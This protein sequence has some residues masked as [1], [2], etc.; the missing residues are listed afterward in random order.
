MELKSCINDPFYFFYTISYNIMSVQ[1]N[2][3]YQSSRDD[4]NF[5]I[6]LWGQPDVVSGQSGGSAIWRTDTLHKTKLFGVPNCLDEYEIRDEAID[7]K[8]PVP[9]KENQYASI[10]IDIDPEVLQFVLNMSG[11]LMYDS[12]QGLLTARGA[13]LADT[14]STLFL[15]LRVV[16]N[17]ARLRSIQQKGAYNRLVRAM[18]KLDGP[19]GINVRV[20]TS[21]FKALCRLKRDLPTAPRKGF[22]RG[23]FDQNG[24]MPTK[25]GK[26]AG[27]RRNSA[28]ADVIVQKRAETVS[29]RDRRTSHVDSKEKIE[30]LLQERVWSDGDSLRAYNSG[31]TASVSAN[32]QTSIAKAKLDAARDAA[33]QRYEDQEKSAPANSNKASKDITLDLEGQYSGATDRNVEITSVEPFVGNPTNKGRL[34]SQ[35]RSA[36]D[37]G[38]NLAQ[39]YDQ[40]F[41]RDVQITNIEPFV[42]NPTNKGRAPSQLRDASD[43]GLNLAQLYDQ[44]FDRDVEITSVEPFRGRQAGPNFQAPSFSVP[45][46]QAGKN[47]TDNW[48]QQLA[49]EEDATVAGTYNRSNAKEHFCGRR[50]Y[51][52]DIPPCRAHEDYR[53][54]RGCDACDNYVKVYH[55]GQRPAESTDPTCFY[56][57]RDDPYVDAAAYMRLYEENVH[58][59]EFTGNMY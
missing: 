41:D 40:A 38:L 27:E 39:L 23:A 45:K 3:E 59:P 34:P 33:Q 7:A 56:G 42:G 22:W 6:R 47:G 11:S 12:L 2:W 55:T 37:I 32:V 36:N 48:A 16:E 19:R 30:D 52:P 43:I 24:G 53:A 51:N 13:N 49:Q 46:F 10:V 31:H 8:F 25:D 15:A 58:D 21:V 20:G 14:I 18:H 26:Y 28:F 29:R 57:R 54:N 50:Q 44:A 17:P 9:R 1:I 4:L 5:L 35:L